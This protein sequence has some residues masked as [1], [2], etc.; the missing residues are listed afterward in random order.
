VPGHPDN[1]SS[2]REHKPL[3]HIIPKIMALIP[4]FVEYFP[5]K[6]NGEGNQCPQA[7]FI[8]FERYLKAANPTEADLHKLG[9]PLVEEAFF[10]SLAEKA[11]RWMDGHEYTSLRDLKV[12]FLRHFSGSLGVSGD[13]Q[14]FNTAK[15]E[16][17]ETVR[18]FKYR[19]STLASRLDLPSSLIKD[20]F[21]NGLPDHIKFQVLP[22][23]D[24]ELEELFGMAQNM[25]SVAR[26]V[27]PETAANLTEIN[28]MRSDM[29]K[30]VALMGQLTSLPQPSYTSAPVQTVYTTTPPPLTN[31]HPLSQHPQPVYMQ[32]APYPEHPGY[33]DV[34]GEEEEL[35]SYFSGGSGPPSVPMGGGRG[36]YHTQPPGAQAPSYSSFRGRGNRPPLGGNF[37]QR[38]SWGF[39]N[40]RGRGAGFGDRSSIICHFCKKPGHIWSK[41]HVLG[42]GVATG[43]AFVKDQDF[44]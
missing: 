42:R 39:D 40:G 8:T 35:G 19:L 17:G 23:Y 28:E 30:L 7:H 21:V 1:F 43:N 37:P 13:L 38:D 24:K 27:K 4:K 33:P 10:R 31:Y 34:S 25:A 15:L 29:G 22:F 26:T 41:S 14:Q 11:I 3:L 32:P 9:F 16:A 20:R 36:S 18:D 12:G 5:R 6:F 2:L 44:H